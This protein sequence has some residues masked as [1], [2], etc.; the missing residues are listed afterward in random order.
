M[1]A[2][3]KLENKVSRRAERAARPYAARR[4]VS[5][6]DLQSSAGVLC[7]VPKH[8]AS[9]GAR[10]RKYLMR[11]RADLVLVPRTEAKPFAVKLSATL[12]KLTLR[13]L[14]RRRIQFATR[15]AGA[16]YKLAALSPESRF[17]PAL[18]RLQD[19]NL[20]ALKATNAEIDARLSHA[21]STLSCIPQLPLH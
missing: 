10:G 2:K 8:G 21:R 3:N 11:T 9:I 13:Q 4:A 7:E 16:K 6:I 20:A 12:A 5:N 1:S 19:I 14:A 15:A 17:R 18:Q